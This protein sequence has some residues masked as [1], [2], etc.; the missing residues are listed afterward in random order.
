MNDQ[1]FLDAVARR[2]GV[3]PDQAATLTRAVLANLAQRI[4]GGEAED[5]AN[6]LSGELGQHLRRSPGSGNAEAFTLGE[7]VRRVSERS[8][9]DQTTATAGVQ[10]VLTTIGEAV[11]GDE[12]K[13]M[14]SQ[15]PKEFLEVIEPVTTGRRAGT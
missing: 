6:Q 2:A 5:I 3:S 11:T 12:F 4:S 10:A 8:G 15:L 13:E 7:F 14:L 9:V 1:E